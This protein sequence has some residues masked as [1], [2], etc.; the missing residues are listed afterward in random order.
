[1]SKKTE[2][3]LNDVDASWNGEGSLDAHREA[4]LAKLKQPGFGDASKP[5][6][7]PQVQAQP[8]KK[9]EQ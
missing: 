7:E 2:A 5:K 9:D 8:I 3:Q 1:M 4:A 6:T